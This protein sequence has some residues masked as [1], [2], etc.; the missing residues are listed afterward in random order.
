MKMPKVLPWIARKAGLT[1]EYVE[2]L[3]SSSLRR[4]SLKQPQL[5][6]NERMAV[7]MQD[8]VARLSREKNAA[9]S[10]QFS[11]LMAANDAGR[12]ATLGSAR[13]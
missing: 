1:D 7:A 2:Q 3:W 8:L 12:L 9:G 13:A 11:P 6:A 10:A 5:A 4:T